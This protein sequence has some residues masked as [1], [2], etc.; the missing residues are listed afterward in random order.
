LGFD[1]YRFDSSAIKSALPNDLHVFAAL[2]DIDC[3]G[4]DLFTSSFFEPTDTYRG[5]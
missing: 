4:N 5:V 3:H 2:A 1:H